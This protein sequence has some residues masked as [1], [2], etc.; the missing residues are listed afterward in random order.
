MTATAPKLKYI[1]APGTKAPNFAIS[2]QDGR[3]HR[4]IDYKSRW[5]VL[6]TYPRDLTPGC[7]VEA[8]DFSAL[9]P[10]FDALACS[11]L[12]VSTD[13]PQKHCRFI[14]KKELT[15]TLLADE[16]HALIE[17]YG[18]WQLKKFMS[19]EN[20]GTIRSTWII[21]PKGMIQAA[22]ESV[23]TKDH[24]QEVLHTLKTL[25]AQ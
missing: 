20:M 22:W 14:E 8:V 23:K 9:K 21:D 5:L 24:A 25:Q 1:V 19:R 16:E 7:T 18:A 3:V 11:L 12:G 13:S 2:D 6:Y 10:E 15:I 4:L 17:A